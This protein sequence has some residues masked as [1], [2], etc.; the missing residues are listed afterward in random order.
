MQPWRAAVQQAAPNVKK[1]SGPKKGSNHFGR[2]FRRGDNQRT[3]SNVGTSIGRRPCPSPHH[4]DPPHWTLACCWARTHGPCTDEGPLDT[5]RSATAPAAR[6]HWWAQGRAAWQCGSVR[7]LSVTF[8]LRRVMMKLMTCG[9][10]AQ[11]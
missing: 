10:V 5:R 7:T 1:G 11:C 2:C 9:G 3:D 8:M 6:M 4:L